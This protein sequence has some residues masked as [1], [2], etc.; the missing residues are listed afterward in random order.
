MIALVLMAALAQSPGYDPDYDPMVGKDSAFHFVT[1]GGIAG[2]SYAGA[3]LF[4]Q[5]RRIRF[6]AALLV[7]LAVSIITAVRAHDEIPG[8]VVAW[9]IPGAVFG[10]TFGLGVDFELVSP[11]RQDH[12]TE[13]GKDADRGRI[14]YCDG[15]TP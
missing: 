13:I 9:G 12:C 5:D 7:P 8:R 10:A 11:H 15:D 14:L 2:L 3:A 1:T 4:T 6:A